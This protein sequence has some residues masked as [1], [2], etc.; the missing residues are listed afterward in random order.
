MG[1]GELAAGIEHTGKGGRSSD[2]GR[3]L[4]HRAINPDNFK[5][6]IY[7]QDADLNLTSRQAHEESSILAE[8]LQQRLLQAKHDDG[9]PVD[10]LVDKRLAWMDEVEGL[11]KAAKASG[12]KI[13]MTD[14][15]AELATSFAGVLDRTPGKENPI[16]PASNIKQGFELIRANRL[17]T[18][19]LLAREPGF[20]YRLFAT[21]PDGRKVL[22]AEMKPLG[23]DE[24]PPADPLKRLVFPPGMET[25]FQTLAPRTGAATQESAST[26]YNQ[27]ITEELIEQL[28]ASLED[29]YRAKLRR[30]LERHIGKTWAAAVD[31]WAA[32][33]APPGGGT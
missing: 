2:E 21:M 8:W 11:V 24:Q 25:I 14:V 26:T 31:E 20:E 7:E 12:R 19:G 10:L 29:S 23:K 15:D 30:S 28:T 18:I 4:R 13:S 9:T 5:Q 27:V 17:A 3:E 33:T 6:E 22:V 32:T 1:P 16:P